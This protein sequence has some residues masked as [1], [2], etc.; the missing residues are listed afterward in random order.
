MI[1]CSRG[2]RQTTPMTLPLFVI[3]D[4]AHQLVNVYRLKI[5]RVNFAVQP[6]HRQHLIE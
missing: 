6:G 3:D 4:G 2:D 5:D 1:P